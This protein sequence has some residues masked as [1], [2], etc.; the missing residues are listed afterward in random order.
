M[1][2]QGSTCSGV[3]DWGQRA[4]RAFGKL[5]VRTKHYFL[6]IPILL[7]FW[8]SVVCVFL[9]FS[10]YFQGIWGFGIAIHLRTNNNFWSLLLSVGE[11]LLPWWMVPFS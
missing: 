1:T 11:C 9:R 3:T 2:F 5:S 7:F 4:N 10:E 6:N 8:F